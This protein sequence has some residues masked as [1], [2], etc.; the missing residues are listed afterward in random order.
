MESVTSA[1]LKTLRKIPAG[2]RNLAANAGQGILLLACWLDGR[3]M[4]KTGGSGYAYAEN[5]GYRCGKS[6]LSEEKES[7]SHGP[8]QNG[9][10]ELSLA[11]RVLRPHF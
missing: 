8:E 1:T 9:C 6:L 2:F 7:G 11:N 3:S 5:F 10:K 4:R